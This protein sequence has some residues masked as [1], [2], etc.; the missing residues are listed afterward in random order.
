MS[1]QIMRTI[2]N[3]KDEGAK[4]DVPPLPHQHTFLIPKDEILLKDSILGG[5]L[6]KG[7]FQRKNH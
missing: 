6:F 7:K 2:F 3:R 1:D 5:I 4:K